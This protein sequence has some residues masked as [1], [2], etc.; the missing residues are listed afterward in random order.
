VL[1]EAKRNN[2]VLLNDM[3][4][5]GKDLQKFIELEFK[6]PVPPSGQ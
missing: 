2:V 5:S 4:I 1:E 6:I 3:A